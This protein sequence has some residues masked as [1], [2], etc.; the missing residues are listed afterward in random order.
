MITAANWLTLIRLAVVPLFWYGFLSDSPL[1]RVLATILF[2][3]GALTDLYDGKLARK[4]REET[5]FGNFTDPLADKL[6]VLSAYW[7]L[8][9]REDFSGLF[10]LA[11]VWISIITLREVGLTLMRILAVGGGSSLATSIWGKWKTGI[12]LTTLIFTLLALN[13]R[14]L[15]IIYEYPSSLFKGTGFF[16]LVNIL[17]F[18]CASS[19]LISGGLYLRGVSNLRSKSD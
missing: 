9:I 2:I 7:A 12:Q 4:R 8:L 19:S 6:L 1:L 17:L 3:G 18:L 11:L 13:L 16:I 5:A 15:L 10:I 14:D